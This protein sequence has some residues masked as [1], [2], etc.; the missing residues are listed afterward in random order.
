MSHGTHLDNNVTCRMQ[1]SNFFVGMSG[2]KKEIKNLI[3]T[4]KDEI[5]FNK[6]LELVDKNLINVLLHHK[7]ILQFS[8]MYLLK[9]SIAYD[10]MT[11]QLQYVDA[12]YQSLCYGK[13]TQ[14]YCLKVVVGYNGT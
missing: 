2:H 3:V 13:M 8:C 4:N 9:D 1:S 5:F 7:A 11:H 6:N 14:L 10:I 12:H